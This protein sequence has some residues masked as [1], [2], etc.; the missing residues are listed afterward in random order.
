LKND[1]ITP[2]ASGYMYEE[3]NDIIVEENI[4]QEN[5]DEVSS[6]SNDINGP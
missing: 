2:L 6:S 5:S 4:I 1:R 3:I